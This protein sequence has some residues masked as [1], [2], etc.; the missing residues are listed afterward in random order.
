VYNTAVT[1]N[2]VMGNPVM[3]SGFGQ[4]IWE[5]TTTNDGL[6]T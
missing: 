4:Q 1:G 5:K 2:P 6:Q 3:G